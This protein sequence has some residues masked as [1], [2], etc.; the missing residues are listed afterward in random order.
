MVE[1]AAIIK[2]IHG[3][4]YSFRYNTE[5]FFH[6]NSKCIDKKYVGTKR[7]AAFSSSDAVMIKPHEPLLI[8][9]LDKA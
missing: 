4:V 9:K 8:L 6:L 1:Y 3:V 5:K 2:Y 7:K